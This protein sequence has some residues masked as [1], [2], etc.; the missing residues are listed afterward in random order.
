MGQTIIPSQQPIL[1][2]TSTCGAFFSLAL[3]LGV[4]NYFV[5]RTK[6]DTHS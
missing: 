4:F 1:A 5:L 2:M 6:K 3:V